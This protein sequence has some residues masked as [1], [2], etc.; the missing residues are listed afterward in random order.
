MPKSR[1]RK[2]QPVPKPAEKPHRWSPPGTYA[3]D[4]VFLLGSGIGANSWT[5]VISALQEFHP[6]ASVT[7]PDHANFWLSQARSRMR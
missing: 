5:P 3:S 6:P 4:T 7:T 1:L 2:K